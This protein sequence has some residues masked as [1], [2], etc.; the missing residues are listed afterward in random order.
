MAYLSLKTDKLHRVYWQS[1]AIQCS[2]W[3]YISMLRPAV[4]AIIRFRKVGVSTP[5][6]VTFY[7]SKILSVISYA[8]PSWFPYLSKGDKERLER[9]QKSYLRVMLPYVECYDEQLAALSLTSATWRLSRQ[10]CLKY[11]ELQPST[12]PLP[13]FR[14]EQWQ[15]SSQISYPT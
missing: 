9:L 7:R 12:S 14:F 15:A 2:C 10:R 3:F 1:C 11:V 6:L 13:K 4:H 5:S 8:A